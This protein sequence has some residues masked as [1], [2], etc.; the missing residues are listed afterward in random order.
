MTKDTEDVAALV[1]MYRTGWANRD[2]A[3]LQSIWDPKYETVYC[4][5]ELD[6]PVLGKASVDQYFDRV[7]ADIRDVHIMTVSDVRIDIIGNVACVFF[8]FHFEG[9]SGA[10]EPFIVHGRNTLIARRTD[11]E[12]KG[13]H[14][15]K[16]LPGPLTLKKL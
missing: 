4:P 2:A 3:T 9:S 7:V 8:S 16:S 14:Y 12:W 10:P 6:R 11:N 15:H 5:A 13:I 1:E